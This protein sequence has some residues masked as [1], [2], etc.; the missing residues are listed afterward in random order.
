MFCD[1]GDSRRG[2]A[3]LRDFRNMRCSIINPKEKTPA[4]GSGRFNL[5]VDAGRQA[6]LI[7]GLNRLGRGL[8]NI[9]EPFMGSDFEL[10]TRLF[11][12]VWAGKHGVTLNPRG[13]R[14]R[15]MHFGV[16]PLSSIHNLHR[17]LVQNRVIVRFHP[18]ANNFSSSGHDATPTE[19]K[20]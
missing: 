4:L 7:Q 16:R 5:D 8:D 12:D 10:L 19:I 2:E 13:Q 6:Q 1:G 9:N 3:Y 17:T 11:I 14:D 15:T 18:N 20:T